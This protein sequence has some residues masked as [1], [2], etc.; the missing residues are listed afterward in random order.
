MK[1]KLNTEHYNHLLI[2]IIFI[3]Y[4]S[5]SNNFLSYLN[6]IFHSLNS[7]LELLIF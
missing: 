7:H 5:L 4:I 1:L 6:C 2:L 3:L